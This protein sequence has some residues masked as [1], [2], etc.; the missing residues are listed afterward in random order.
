MVGLTGARHNGV[1]PSRSR[2]SYAALCAGALL[3]LWFLR[4]SLLAVYGHLAEVTGIDGRWLAAVLGCE[5]LAFI[6]SWELVR[7]A[8]RTDRW[9]D[10]AVARLMGNAASNVVPA[11]GPVGA[12]VQ[13]RL[14]S[15]AAST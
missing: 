2:L 12:A 10:V 15:E 8:L 1:T 13:L 3:A 11:G 14:L 7:L 9:F 6:A 4:S 5:T